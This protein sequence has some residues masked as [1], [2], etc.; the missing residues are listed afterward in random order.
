M[1]DHH[2]YKLGSDRGQQWRVL[3]VR[4]RCERKAAAALNDNGINTLLPL[5]RV[6]KAGTQRHHAPLFPGYLF[7]GVTPDSGASVPITSIPGTIGW[8]SFDGQI[9]TVSQSDIA[10][11]LDRLGD[12]NRNGG[13]WREYSVGDIVRV[14]TGHIDSLGEVIE[15]PRSP[16]ARIKV[17]LRLMGQQVRASVPTHCLSPASSE[18]RLPR[19]RR[20]TRGRGRWIQYASS[21]AQNRRDPVAP[22]R[23]TSSTS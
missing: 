7:V 9:P 15:S 10:D 23:R 4:P 19:R 17:L 22:H 11:V 2:R 21:G 5:I 13:V 20:R 1:T 8:V 3:R 16:D 6:P 18:E 14:E 12:L